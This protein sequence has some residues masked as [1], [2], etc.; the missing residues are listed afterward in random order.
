MAAHRAAGW[1]EAC[2]G[3]T[4]F[5]TLRLKKAPVLRPAAEW[6]R[7]CTALCNLQIRPSCV[8]DSVFIAR[9][10]CSLR[11]LHSVL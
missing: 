2:G 9:L 7:A 3:R 6:M 8:V 4:R 5:S 1:I 10:F 11:I